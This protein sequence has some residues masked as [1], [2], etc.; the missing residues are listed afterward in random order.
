[1]NVLPAGTKAPDFQTA[2]LGGE[3]LSLREALESGPVVLCFAAPH[4][5]ASRLVVGY[6]RRLRERAPDLPVWVVLQGDEQAVLAY[7]EGY[8]EGLKV[9]FDEHFRVSK[10]YGVTH[11]PSSYYLAPDGLV[12]LSFSGFSRPA[13]NKLADLA[14][15]ATGAKNK[16]LITAMDNKGEYE[17]AERA[18][19]AQG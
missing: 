17:L 12:E 14:A 2:T 11:V 4:I 10:P 1:M 16:E 6:L 8:L 3:A 19:S 7:V 13:M 9:V 15:Q 5:H 18:P